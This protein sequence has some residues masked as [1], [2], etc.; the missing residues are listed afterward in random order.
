MNQNVATDRV[1][2]FGVVDHVASFLRFDPAC[3]VIKGITEQQNMEE[4]TDVMAIET[5][6]TPNVFEIEDIIEKVIFERG[7]EKFLVAVI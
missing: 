7:E 6:V 5:G 4:A 1:A 2:E 3:E